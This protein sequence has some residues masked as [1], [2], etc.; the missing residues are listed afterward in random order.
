MFT[1]TTAVCHRAAVHF[2]IMCYMSEDDLELSGCCTWK[3]FFF[4]MRM[5]L[6]DNF[7]AVNSSLIVVWPFWV[8]IPESL[9]T[10]VVN[11]VV[12]CF[13][14]RCVLYCTVLYCTV[15]YCTVLLPPGVNPIAVNKY[16]KM[17]VLQ[18]QSHANNSRVKSCNIT[19]CCVI[20]LWSENLH[21]LYSLLVSLG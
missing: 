4:F 14:Y 8:R 18:W 6:G 9:P 13:V 17:E 20:W 10:K 11:C 5:T 16:I 15:L 3:S 12:Q 19:G 2:M 7:Y 21:N 1:D